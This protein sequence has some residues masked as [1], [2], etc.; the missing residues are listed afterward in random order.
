MIFMYKNVK[1][2]EYEVIDEET[3]IEKVYENYCEMRD[4]NSL[5]FVPTFAYLASG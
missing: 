3:S 1:N 4:N 2:E 5:E